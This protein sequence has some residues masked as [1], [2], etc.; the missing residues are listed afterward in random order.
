MVFCKAGVLLQVENFLM[1][2]MQVLCV[3]DVEYDWVF[4]L[5]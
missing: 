4:D 3:V 1:T 2:C 5:A